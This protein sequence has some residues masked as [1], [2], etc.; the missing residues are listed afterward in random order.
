MLA[1]PSRLTVTG[2]PAARL[3]RSRRPVALPDAT[4]WSRLL[5]LCGGLAGLTSFGCVCA[6]HRIHI[7]LAFLGV[8]PCEVQYERAC[9]QTGANSPTA[10]RPSSLN[11]IFATPEPLV[12]CGVVAVMPSSFTGS[13]GF[14]LCLLGVDF[15][16]CTEQR[17]CVSHR[18]RVERYSPSILRATLL[19]GQACNPDSPR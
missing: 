18:R 2:A 9:H 3:S 10:P 1:R 14:H 15:V 8:G 11:E 7:P 16:R 5:P 6:S 13:T 4:V 19:E 12:G 17:G